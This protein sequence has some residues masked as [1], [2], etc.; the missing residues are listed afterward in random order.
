MRRAEDNLRAIAQL[1]AARKEFDEKLTAMVTEEVAIVKQ[2]ISIRRREVE[3]RIATLKKRKDHLAASEARLA[4]DEA[5][6]KTYQDLCSAVLDVASRIDKAE[7][8]RQNLTARKNTPQSAFHKWEQQFCQPINKLANLIRETD[9][10]RKEHEREFS[11]QRMATQTQQTQAAE[12]L[13]QIRHE[14]TILEDEKQHFLVEKREW[15]SMKGKELTGAEMKR[16]MEV[17]LEERIEQIK[18]MLLEE[19]KLS[20]W[21]LQ[22]QDSKARETVVITEAKAQG[23]RIGYRK[24]YAEGQ[25]QEDDQSYS[26]GRKD[27]EREHRARLLEAMRE[28]YD[29]GRDVGYEA[30]WEENFEGQNISY[31]KG[32]DAG[33][34]QGHQKGHAK[35]YAEGLAKGRQLGDEAGRATFYQEGYGNGQDEGRAEGN[36]LGYAAGWSKGYD[37][38][39]AGGKADERQANSKSQNAEESRLKLEF[40]RGVESAER[41][42]TPR[43]TREYDAGKSRGY[44]KGWDAGWVAAKDHFNRR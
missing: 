8:G 32:R 16:A 12:L 28:S 3:V 43:L 37:V 17:Y 36:R 19:A 15:R 44:N 1:D 29:E 22:Q 30:G 14:Q 10:E 6:S 9:D 18:P 34:S 42:F 21:T 13:S 39:H 33:H 26:I 5:K 35:G 7:R 11:E 24:G 38:G 31:Q 2:D 23:H 27:A 25:E 20:N 41:E 40:D 4:R